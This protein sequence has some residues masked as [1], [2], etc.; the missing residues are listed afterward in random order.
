VAQTYD[1]CPSQ[2]KGNIKGEFG[3]GAGG[4]KHRW[5][6]KFGEEVVNVMIPHV[7][8]PACSPFIIKK[9]DGL[10]ACPHAV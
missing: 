6:P 3:P 8:P 10:S 9:I 2:R 1:H 7:Y 4:A 5:L